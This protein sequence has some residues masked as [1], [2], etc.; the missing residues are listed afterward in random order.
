[1]IDP[2]ILGVKLVTLVLSL[3]VAYLAYHG[4]K[5]SANSPMLYVAV[6]FV[7]IGVGAVCESLIYQTFDT[8]L[9]SAAFAQSVIVSSGMLFVLASLTFG[10]D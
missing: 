7:F 6:G 9:R 10:S 4:Y 8:S 1:M 2:P 5:R 3:L